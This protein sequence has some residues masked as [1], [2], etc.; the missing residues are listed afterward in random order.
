VSAIADSFVHV[1]HTL[2]GDT[3]SMPELDVPGTHIA[4]FVS[5]NVFLFIMFFFF[6][7]LSLSLSEFA[8][9]EISRHTR[10]DKRHHLAFKKELYRCLKTQSTF[11]PCLAEKLN[12]DRIALLGSYAST[13]VSATKQKPTSATEPV[14]ASEPVASSG[15]A[16]EVSVKS[17]E[18]V[19]VQ[20][21]VSN[22]A[23]VSTSDADL[24]AAIAKI[25]L[26]SA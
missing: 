5:E 14:P 22:A 1:V 16:V 19:D 11:W 21:A 13:P 2:L 17:E 10:R 15:P 9:T 7:S 24:E 6:F 8:C 23:P 12:D 18:H 4:T 20:G 26:N 25:N 3:V